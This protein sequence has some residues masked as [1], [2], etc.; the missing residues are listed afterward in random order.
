MIDFKRIISVVVV[1]SLV[2]CSCGDRNNPIRVYEGE[3]SVQ[4]I[5]TE[6]GVK[7]SASKADIIK[8]TE[9]KLSGRYKHCRLNNKTGYSKCTREVGGSSTKVVIKKVTYNNQP[10]TGA[11]MQ[12]ILAVADKGEGCKPT[13]VKCVSRA[14]SKGCESH[15]QVESVSEEDARK[16]EELE[17]K[18]QEK[19]KR[20]RLYGQLDKKH[21]KNAK[22]AVERE[23]RVAEYTK[24][25]GEAL[26]PEAIKKWG[27]LVKQCNAKDETNS[28]ACSEE[29]GKFGDLLHD[30][31]FVAGAEKELQSAKNAL[32]TCTGIPEEDPSFVDS[33]SNYFN[34]DRK[35]GRKRET[36]YNLKRKNDVSMD[37]A[38]AVVKKLSK[39][40]RGLENILK[41]DD[42]NAM[43]EAKESNLLCHLNQED[44]FWRSYDFWNTDNFVFWTG[45]GFWSGDWWKTRASFLVDFVKDRTAKNVNLAPKISSWIDNHLPSWVTNIINK[46]TS[47]VEEG[48]AGSVG[49]LSLTISNVISFIF[50]S[51]SYLALTIG[52]IAMSS[53]ESLSVGRI[54]GIGA[55][56]TVGSSLVNAGVSL[57][58]ARSEDSA[59]KIARNSAKNNILSLSAAGAGGLGIG[60]SRLVIG[61]L[62]FPPKAAAPAGGQQQDEAAVG[63]MSPLGLLISRELVAMGV[64]PKQKQKEALRSWLPQ[65]AGGLVRKWWSA[66]PGGWLWWTKLPAVAPPL[67]LWGASLLLAPFEVALRVI[68]WCHS[69]IPKWITGSSIVGMYFL[70]RFVDWLV[71]KVWTNPSPI[72]TSMATAALRGY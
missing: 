62:I 65:K 41:S 8:G 45:K 22:E 33:I 53:F 23:T 60:F 12:C 46:K 20:K 14:G 26:T 29:I 37:A 32:E 18:R 5:Y 10:F 51:P 43:C 36:F 47:A 16:A 25:V 72:V 28:S 31:F 2:L 56:T 69:M 34:H 27:S 3:G 64:N 52:C 50:L 44:N 4:L 30:T 15:V 38:N 57:L 19:E 70:P 61:T 39:K 67:A 6:N 13:P 35:C 11:D 1:F 7:D 40:V 17:K 58:V 71:S 21:Q 49:L 48:S 55:L 68:G 66:A 54:I 59:S 63:P 24:K 42:F 9:L